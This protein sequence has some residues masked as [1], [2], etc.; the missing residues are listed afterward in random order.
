MILLFQLIMSVRNTKNFFKNMFVSGFLF[1]ST[2]PLAYATVTALH[3][4]PEP[5][6]TIG[7]DVPAVA[8]WLIFYAGLKTVTDCIEL[9]N[10]KKFKT[11]QSIAVEPLADHQA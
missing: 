7:L 6:G 10:L 3:Y 2:L 1:G 8:F 4:L 11:V 5:M 9:F